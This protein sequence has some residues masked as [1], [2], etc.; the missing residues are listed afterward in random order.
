MKRFPRGCAFAILIA[1][2]LEGLRVKQ[3]KA[4]QHCK[5]LGQSALAL[6]MLLP[7]FSQ[8]LTLPAPAV[9]HTIGATMTMH[10]AVLLALRN[11]PDIISAELDRVTDKYALIL[12]R[13]AYMPQFTLGGKFTAN[14]GTAATG[15]V[16]PLKVAVDHS[17]LGVTGS[18]DYDPSNG[19]MNVDLKKELWAGNSYIANMDSLWTAQETAEIAELTYRDSIVTTIHKTTQAF[20]A[21]AASKLTLANDQFTLQT[22]LEQLKDAKLKL[23]LGRGTQFDVNQSKLDVATDKSTIITDKQNIQSNRVALNEV[24]GLDPEVQIHIANDI[25]LPHIVLGK[26]SDAKTKA[27]AVSTAYKQAQIT[28]KQAQR[29]L[30]ID[31]NAG[32][33]TLSYEMTGTLGGNQNNVTNAITWGIPIDNVQN[34]YDVIAD[35]IAIIK[36]KQALTTTRNSIISSVTLDY[37]TLKQTVSSWLLA[38]QK[39]TLNEETVKQQTAQYQAGQLGLYDLSTA[40]QG[41]TTTRNNLQTTKD[42][43]WD[44]LEAYRTD[45][46]TV[47]SSWGVSLRPFL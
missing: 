45:T 20:R 2:T 18:L 23:K 47:L 37:N 14:P 3:N 1:L 39:L 36:D 5:R 46:G 6:A 43:L 44:A 28:L 29:K 12:A 38:N 22:D 17:A 8:A 19:T 15:S 30:A 40:K 27:L 7:C 34:K 10:E 24:L 25:P 35:R 26:L 9:T 21:L 32:K 11:N 16:D 13:H 4:L 41:L 42:S 33:P 31:K